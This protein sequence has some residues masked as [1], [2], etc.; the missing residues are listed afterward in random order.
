MFGFLTPSAKE[1]VDPL[2]SAKVVSAWLRELPALDVIGRQQHVMRAFETMR[3]S[4]K[5]V[6]L[7]RLHAVQFVD[8]A[9]GA[10]R[11][12]LIKQYVENVDAAPKLAERLW[13]SVFELAQGYVQAYTSLIEVAL[14]Q[15]G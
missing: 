10:D 6:D 5:P 9:L 4:R 2:Q 12:Q 8:A 14:R 15:S 3:K 1:T 11:R 7:G 13:H